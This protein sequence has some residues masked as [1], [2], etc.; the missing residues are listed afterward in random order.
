MKHTHRMCRLRQIDLKQF[1]RKTTHFYQRKGRYKQNLC[2]L[3]QQVV[4]AVPIYL[5]FDGRQQ[6]KKSIAY[7]N[8][9]AKDISYGQT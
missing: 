9:V 8:I 6:K 3:F 7:W 4:I 1:C 5:T 2:Y